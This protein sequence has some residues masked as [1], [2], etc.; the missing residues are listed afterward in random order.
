MHKNPQEAIALSKGLMAQDSAYLAVANEL[1]FEVEKDLNTT[2]RAKVIQE[3]K[4][5]V[6]KLSQSM[7]QTPQ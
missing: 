4:L 7:A 3:L 2:F 6:I 1:L 5:N